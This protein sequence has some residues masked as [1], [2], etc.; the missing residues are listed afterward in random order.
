MGV[1]LDKMNRSLQKFQREISEYARKVPDK[2]TELQKKLVLEALRRIVLSTPVD[3]GRAR[4]NWQV[5]LGT[6]AEGKLE[7]TDQ[8]GS[9]TIQKGVA[10]LD[11]LPPFQCVWISNNLEYIEF[12]ED[13]SSQQAPH[14]M[15]RLTVTQL[16]MALRSGLK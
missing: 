9:D 4:G 10:V 13:G 2:I 8:N 5:T 14:G 3:T 11:G 6:P 1:E 12:L 15:V 16:R 7:T